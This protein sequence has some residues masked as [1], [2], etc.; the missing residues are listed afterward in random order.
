[1]NELYTSV[2]RN[3]SERARQENG[4]QSPV[5]SGAVGD[6]PLFVVRP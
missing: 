4:K 6:L 3:V 2:Q 1:V 5:I